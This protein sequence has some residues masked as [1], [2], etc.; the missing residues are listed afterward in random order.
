MCYM[1]VMLIW[2]FFDKIYMI[3][4]SMY[5]SYIP[6]DWNEILALVWTMIF[7]WLLHQVLVLMML[8][9]FFYK[10]HMLHV[11]NYVFKTCIQNGLVFI[12]EQRSHSCYI[13]NP[14]NNCL[15]YNMCVQ[16]FLPS[17]RGDNTGDINPAGSNHPNDNSGD[18]GDGGSGGT[19]GDLRR[20]VLAKG[21]KNMYHELIA[22]EKI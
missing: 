16:N 18:G 21:W 7:F 20:M 13:L 10:I 19:S 3:V 2:N 4:N 22:C 14:A 8:V 12:L 15:P 1:N 17:L 11:C 9:F 5:R 6:D